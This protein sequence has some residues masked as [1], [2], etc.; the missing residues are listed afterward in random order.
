MVGHKRGHLC[1]EAGKYADRT[2]AGL[3]KNAH[4]RADSEVRSGLG[5]YAS[6]ILDAHV[7]VND[8]TLQT[9]GHTAYKH[10]VTD[11]AI[12]DNG[13][14]DTFLTFR[15]AIEYAYFYCPQEAAETY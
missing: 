15:G 12:P 13:V 1:R 9:P 3:V 14:V 8:K 4:C 11:S 5:D 7:I 2:R 10:M 6:Y